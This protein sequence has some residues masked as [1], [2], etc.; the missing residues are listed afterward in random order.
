MHGWRLTIGKDRVGGGE[1]GQVGGEGGDACCEGDV[2]N[3]KVC[4]RGLLL[5]GNIGQVIQIAIE[6][7]VGG[8]SE[9]G[10]HVGGDGMR[11]PPLAQCPPD[12][13]SWRLRAM[14]ASQ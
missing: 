7:R 14:W 9:E 1:F 5:C 12:A 8:Q 11:S 4:E 3:H 10:W 13:S 6:L 2:G